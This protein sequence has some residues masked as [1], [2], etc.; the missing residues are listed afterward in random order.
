MPD[1]TNDKKSFI[2]ALKWTGGEWLLALCVMLLLLAA[3]YIIA[4]GRVKGAEHVQLDKKQMQI[5]KKYFDNNPDTGAVIETRKSI[6]EVR[7]RL[8]MLFLKGEYDDKLSG[9]LSNELTTMLNMTGNGEAY[10]YLADKKMLM[11]SYFWLTGS[12][13]YLEAWLWC[14]IGVLA[15]LIYYVSIANT[16]SLTTAGD[17]DSGSFNPGEIPGQIGKMFYAP[18]VTIVLILGYHYLSGSNSNMIDISVNNGLIVFS[19][20]AGFFSGRLMKFLDKLKELILPFSSSNESPAGT[21]APAT[22]TGSDTTVQLQ[23][24]PSLEQSPEG[25][26]IIENGFNAAEVILTPDSGGDPI[27][28]VNPADDQSD[29]FSATQ[30]RSGKYS[31][32]ATMTYK[33]DD[34]TII[35]MAGQQKVEISKTSSSFTLLLDKTEDSG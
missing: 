33:K 14:L 3:G 10:D 32:K 21:T 25:P 6:R 12:K 4:H 28:L 1:T 18:A 7:T 15:S 16:K 5:I 24:S 23:L 27:T 20:I 29:V 17:E 31:L 22:V 34:R 19:F 13:T 35:N 30:V 26:D 11:Q 8:V 9:T 2:N